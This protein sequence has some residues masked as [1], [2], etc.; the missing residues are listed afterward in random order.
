MIYTSIACI[1][2]LGGREKIASANN[3]P[4][5]TISPTTSDSYRL[6]FDLGTAR[7]FASRFVKGSRTLELRITPATAAEFETSSYYD[8]RYVKR[9]VLREDGKEVILGLQLKNIPIRWLITYQENPWRLVVDFWRD[10]ASREETL[11]EGWNW[12]HDLATGLSVAD[13]TLTPTATVAPGAT[14]VPPISAPQVD[15]PRAETRTE[16]EART[17]AINSSV[18]GVARNAMLPE[19]FGRIEPRDCGSSE[20]LS[21]LQRAVGGSVGTSGEYPQSLVLARQLYLCDRF[22]EASALLKRVAALSERDFEGDAEA[23][24]IAGESAYLTG[25]RE[26]AVDY[27]RAILLRHPNKQ[28]AHFATLR[29]VDLEYLRALATQDVQ[30]QEGSRSRYAEMAVEEKNATQVRIVSALRV[31]HETIDKNPGAAGLYRQVVDTCVNKAIVPFEMRRNCSYIKA[32]SAVDLLDVLQADSEVRKFAEFSD[33]D[34]RIAKLEEKIV[35]RV[36]STLAESDKSRNWEPW[37][38]LEK[39][40]RPELLAFTL[41]DHLSLRSRAEA[42]ESVGDAKRAA[43]F[44]ALS[45]DAAKDM[46]ESDEI[47]AYA[48][49]ILRR[50]KNGGKSE[51]FVGKVAKSEF[52]RRNGLS[53]KATELMRELSLPPYRSRAALQMV[54]DEMA[55]GRFVERDLGALVDYTRTLPNAKNIDV[56]YEKI[57]AYPAKSPGEISTVEN[58]VMGYAARLATQKATRSKAADIYLSVAKFPQGTRRAEAALR[59]GENYYREGEFEKAKAAWQISATD[60]SRNSFSAK[61][62]EWLDKSRR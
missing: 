46:P 32:R 40:G 50:A 28:R 5:Q 37:L 24:W 16:D 15:V 9:V 29:L 14:M 38:A 3:A 26:S 43:Q 51:F 19:N 7:R 41:K 60:V 31:L 62:E 18:T 57:G 25:R 59:A 2:H 58:S 30:A 36:R 48:A 1:A 6:S 11:E 23:L 10:E 17:P 33:N 53:P 4:V 45:Y 55:S 21:E 49:R 35:Q 52:R 44:Y 12:Q 47:A 39:A 13:G 61:A 20:R 8:T 34:S 56:V 54:F 27:F 42:W 22:G